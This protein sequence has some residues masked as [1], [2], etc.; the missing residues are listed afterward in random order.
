MKEIR[1]QFSQKGRARGWG[2]LRD[3]QKNAKRMMHRRTE[4]PS[5]ILE[6]D[7][8]PPENENNETDHILRRHV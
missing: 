7:Y 8:L 5:P 4:A 3:E 1:D 2:N 6:N